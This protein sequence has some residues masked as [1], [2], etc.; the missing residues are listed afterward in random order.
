[1][2]E[3][4]ARCFFLLGQS[5]RHVLVG[6][7]DLRVGGAGVGELVVGVGVLQVP[8][9]ARH[10]RR[11]VVVAILLGNDLEEQGQG[12]NLTVLYDDFFY[13]L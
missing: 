7:L 4:V 5:L 3:G 10:V 1:M 8:P 12:L 13:I 2:P 11:D 9:H 6:D